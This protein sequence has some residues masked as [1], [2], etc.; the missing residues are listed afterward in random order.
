MKILMMKSNR[1]YVKI[2]RKE[3]A[4]FQNK[5]ES[6]DKALGEFRNC[7]MIDPSILKSKAFKIIPEEFYQELEHD[8]ICNISPKSEY[9]ENVFSHNIIKKLQKNVTLA[10]LSGYVKFVVSP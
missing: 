5:K 9:R 6:R 1:N 3:N 2:I 4:I 8:Y 7:S 10:N